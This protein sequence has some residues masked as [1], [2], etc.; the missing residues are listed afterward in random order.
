MI[1]SVYECCLTY[2]EHSDISYVV[3]TT[4][5]K[6]RKF[7]EALESM[8]TDPEES[9]KNYGDQGYGGIFLCGSCGWYPDE[10]MDNVAIEARPSV[11]YLVEKEVVLQFRAEEDMKMDVPRFV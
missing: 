3:D 9:D 5:L 7:A 10:G 6:D 2:R 11:P 1:V 8:E 4:L